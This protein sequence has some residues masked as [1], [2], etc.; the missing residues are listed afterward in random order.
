MTEA[1]ELPPFLN[2]PDEAKARSVIAGDDQGRLQIVA[3]E[4]S[5]IDASDIER[6]TGRRLSVVP[7][8]AQPISALPGYYGLPVLIDER[9]TRLAQVALP[10]EEPNHFL[11][12][13]GKAVAA[14]TFESQVAD[15]CNDL[16]PEP[17]AT[18]RSDDVHA[19][20]ACVSR[21]TERVI[22]KRLDD[23]LHIP[24]L[25]ETARRVIR[26]SQD[27]NYDLDELVAII[28]TDPSLAARILGWAN[29]AFYG[30]GTEITSVHQAIVRVLGADL[31]MNMALGLALADTLR[32][33][34][35]SVR[36]ISPYW[37]NAVFTA[38]A[39]EALARKI[40]DGPTPGLAY[41]SGLL[42]DLGTLILGHVFPPHYERVCLHQD[43]NRHVPRT[44]VDARILGTTREVIASALLE[45]WELPQAIC[46]SVRFQYA[47]AYVG[48][49]ASYVRLLRLVHQVLAAEG[50]NDYPKDHLDHGLIKALALGDDAINDVLTVISNSRDELDGFA[51]AV[52]S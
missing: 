5:F 17:T 41:L 48:E 47:R 32:T 35:V 16:G 43:L 20:Y 27:P 26:M 25:S 11:K 15:I 21:L 10:T 31:V 46:D 2:P 42:A 14:I 8:G 39:S 30:T 52:A 51:R 4:T 22:E 29:S 18:D 1:P 49:H 50:I 6:V 9:V 7:E 34:D 13:A 36:G 23:L 40:P 37:L 45:L 28:E 3:L 12:S 33:P 38:A 24:P 44:F 19:I